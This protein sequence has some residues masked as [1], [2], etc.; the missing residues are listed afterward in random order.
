MRSI[1]FLNPGDKGSVP[2]DLD[3][4]RERITNKLLSLE[5]PCSKP[6]GASIISFFTAIIQQNS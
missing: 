4:Y 1:T 2:E 5:A 6:R 3:R